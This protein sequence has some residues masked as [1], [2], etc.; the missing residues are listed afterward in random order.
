MEG[1]RGR[2]GFC[3]S[4]K[5]AK[6]DA[7]RGDRVK[8]FFESNGDALGRV[9][10]DNEDLHGDALRAVGEEVASLKGRAW[11]FSGDAFSVGQGGRRLR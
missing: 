10:V 8:R 7:W 9:G 11:L 3:G 5:V 4:R 1:M 6:L 2:R